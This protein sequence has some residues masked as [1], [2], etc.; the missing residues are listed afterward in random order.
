MLL[1][2]IMVMNMI[3]V[4]TQFIQRETKLV[5]SECGE[6]TVKEY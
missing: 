2:Y 3:V 1:E 4:S 5:S 6:V